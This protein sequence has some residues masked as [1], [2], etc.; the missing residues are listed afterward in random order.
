MKRKFLRGILCFCF[1]S[2]A[3]SLAERQQ[4][5]LKVY[6][7][8]I[9]S[10]EYVC[11][12]KDEEIRHLQYNTRGL[13]GCLTKMKTIPGPLVEKPPLALTVPAYTTVC[14]IDDGETI[15]VDILKAQDKE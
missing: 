11:R 6:E 3:P 13:A 10:L 12:N 5:Q 4:S 2:C 7:Q 8:Q 15:C 14:I 1:A 9:S